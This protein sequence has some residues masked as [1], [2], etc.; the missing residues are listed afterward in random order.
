MALGTTAAYAVI[1]RQVAAVS[2]TEASAM[3]HDLSSGRSTAPQGDECA[4]TLLFRP[5]FSRGRG[6]AFPCD[7]QGRVD[8]DAI[9]ER[10]RNNYFYARA[11]IGREL[12]YPSVQRGASLGLNPA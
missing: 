10:C 12:T 5:L 3:D 8:L 2:N 11:M 9:S 1:K 4:C 6:F 7:L